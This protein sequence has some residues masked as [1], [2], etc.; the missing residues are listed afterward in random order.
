[1]TPLESATIALGG[2]AIRLLACEGRYP[3]HRLAALFPEGRSEPLRPRRW[4]GH[5]VRTAVSFLPALVLALLLGPLLG[6]VAGI[7]PAC[8]V[9]WWLYRRGTRDSRVD[10]SRAAVGLPIAIDLMVAGMRAGGTMTGVLSAVTP[11]VGGPLGRELGGVADRLRLGADPAAAWGGLHGPP[12]LVAVGRA[13]ARAGETGAPVAD[14]LERQAAEVRR[15]T[16]TRAYADT[17]RLGVLVVA[18][19]GLC[20]LPAF[21]LIGVVPLAAG[22]LSGLELP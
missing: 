11:A 9:W 1:M 14:I 15:R 8:A 12:E 18:P 4:R 3:H 6:L 13:L 5:G 17:Q 10:R 21:V 20:F 2:L 19:L 7:P 16:R 22:L